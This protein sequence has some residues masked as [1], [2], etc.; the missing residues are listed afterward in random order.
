MTS[1]D[2]LRLL[3]NTPKDKHLALIEWFF[4]QKESGKP[5]PTKKTAHSK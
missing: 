5:G 1:D 4:R 3:A 2:F